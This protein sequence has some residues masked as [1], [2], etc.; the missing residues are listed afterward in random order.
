VKFLPNHFANYKGQLTRA[1]FYMALELGIAAV[2]VNLPSIWVVFVNFGPEAIV[3]SVR[4]AVSLA[5]F[6][7]RGSRA[8]RDTR[9]N[10]EAQKS[11]T[12]ISSAAPLPVGRNAK[13]DEEAFDLEALNSARGDGNHVKHDVS[14]THV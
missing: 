9:N 7:S 5:S 2:A 13:T 8:S 12:S 11:A 4:S 1:V 6:G 14:V 10:T 3:R